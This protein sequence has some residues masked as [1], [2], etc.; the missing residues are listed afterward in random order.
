MVISPDNVACYFFLK[1]AS[2]DEGPEDTDAG[3]LQE[4]LLAI[5]KVLSLENY[6][7][8]V[9]PDFVDRVPYLHHLTQS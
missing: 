7:F 1:I 5:L 4:D 2:V 3:G 6:F 8:C 9:N